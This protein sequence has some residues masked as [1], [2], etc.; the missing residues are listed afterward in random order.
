M[1]R[2]GGRAGTKYSRREGK[3]L[4][5]VAAV[6]VVAWLFYAQ[7]TSTVISGRFQREKEQMTSEERGRIGRER[8]KKKKRPT[9]TTKKEKGGE[10][11]DSVRGKRVEWKF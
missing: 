11:G 7:S 10:R 6:V 3:D 1:G 9:T 5:G 8:K 2:G 4:E